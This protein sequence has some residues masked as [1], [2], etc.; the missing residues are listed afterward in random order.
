MKKSGIFLLIVTMVLLTLGNPNIFARNNNPEKLYSFPDKI[1]CISTYKNFVFV[2]T[3]SGFFVSSDSGQT[4]TERD[5]GLN[6]SEITGIVFLKGKLF[7]GTANAGLYVSSNF[8]KSWTSLMNKLNCPTISSVKTDGS[9]IFVTSFCTGFHYSND[10]GQ[11]WYERNNGLPTVR[12][13]TFLKVSNNRYFLGTEQ[14]GLFYTDTLNDNCKWSSFLNNYTVTS[15]SYINNSLLVGTNSGVFAGDI[16]NGNFKKL[17][18]IGGNPYII[19]MCKL[20]D[21]ILVAV[22]DFGIFASSDAKNFLNLGI[23][24]FSEVSAIYFNEKSKNLYVGT[25]EGDLWKL[26]LSG[27]FMITKK[28]IDLGSVVKGNKLQG[29]L[30]ILNL[31]SSELTGNVQSPYFI[32]FANARVNGNCKLYFTVKTDS[33]SEGEYSEPVYINTNGG[34]AVVYINFKI[35][36]PSAI[37]IKLKIGSHDAYINSKQ[38]YLDAPPFINPEAGRTLVP[39]RFISDA[40]GADVEWNPIERKVT[41]KLNPTEHHG[42]VLVEL[43]INNKT[44][45]VNLKK[46]TIDVA[47]EIVPPGRTMVPLRFIAEVFGSNVEWDPVNRTVTI[48]YNP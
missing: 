27:S 30:R 28:M 22:K 44:V 12:T 24:E 35:E 31:G 26:D 36:K 9:E 5:Q 10:F 25:L 16:T 6:D 13:T 42:A 43:W 48:I 15:L 29:N 41:V 47:P 11:T 8:G 19:D 33:L 32:K 40:F 7:L 20:P 1:T 14:Y 21:Y 34:K 4:F 46:K 37:I 3:E 38:I 17:K 23:D 2:G 39:V 18:F 45:S